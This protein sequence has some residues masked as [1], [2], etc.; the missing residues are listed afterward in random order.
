M[1][2]IHHKGNL[3]SKF[4]RTLKHVYSFHIYFPQW[5]KYCMLSQGHMIL[6]LYPLLLQWPKNKL[7]LLLK[8]VTYYWITHSTLLARNTTKDHIQYIK[9]PIWIWGLSNN[10]FLRFPGLKLSQNLKK[11]LG[12][13]R[14]KEQPS[15]MY[16]N[17]IINT[18]EFWWKNV[19]FCDLSISAAT[20]YSLY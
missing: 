5:Q 19:G 13:R 17:V 11:G 6:P 8:I 1:Y 3:S 18:I 15:N 10:I 9:N 14:K 7:P 2:N 12:M 4:H 20:P 16:N